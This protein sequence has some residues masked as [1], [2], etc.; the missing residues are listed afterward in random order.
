MTFFD[1]GVQRLNDY[2]RKYA[3]TNHQNRSADVR[4]MRGERVVGYYTLAAAPW[5]ARKRRDAWPKVW[6][7]IPCR[8]S[9]LPD[10]PST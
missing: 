8:S 6:A 1:C 2:L 10:W 3:L 4:R 5:A 7:S 9:C